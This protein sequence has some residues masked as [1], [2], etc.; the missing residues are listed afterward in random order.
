MLKMC[1]GS[2]SHTVLVPTTFQG[3]VMKSVGIKWVWVYVVCFQNSTRHLLLSLDTL[4]PWKIYSYIL[5]ITEGKVRNQY[6]MN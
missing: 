6:K 3:A 4:S 2:A 1:R 5:Y